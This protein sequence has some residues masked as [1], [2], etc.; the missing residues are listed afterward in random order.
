MLRCDPNGKVGPKKPLPDCVEVPGPKEEIIPT[1]PSSDLKGVKMDM[2]A[3]V[4][5]VFD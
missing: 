3:A 5:W 1:V 2:I 4:A